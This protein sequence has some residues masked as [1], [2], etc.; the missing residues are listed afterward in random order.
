MLC[1][2]V[3]DVLKRAGVNQIATGNK[4]RQ[5][6]RTHGFRKFFINQCD[7][8]NIIYS[9]RE[10][11]VGHTMPNQDPS[12]I[13]KTEEDMLSEYVKAIPLPIIEPTAEAGTA[14]Y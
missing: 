12:Y 5:V 7:K 8:V 1:F 10:H 14:E 2:V 3:E 13:R 11:L 6:I 9:V 4:R